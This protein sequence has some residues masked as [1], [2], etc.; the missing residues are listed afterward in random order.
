MFGSFFVTI[1]CFNFFNFV[2]NLLF[3]IIYFKTTKY[4]FDMTTCELNN[5][6]M[7]NYHGFSSLEI[8]VII[9]D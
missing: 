1:F 7:A 8:M 2:C 5:Q 3:I 4:W 6:L 9:V